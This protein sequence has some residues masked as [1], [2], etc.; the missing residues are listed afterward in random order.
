M[1]RAERH[2]EEERLVGR[3]GAFFD[4][5]DGFLG[6]ARQVVDLIQ[7]F[8]D[9]V[10]LDDGVHVARMMDAMK[11]VKATMDGT[12][13]NGGSDR[14]APFSRRLRKDRS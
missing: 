7:T 9:L 8:D 11:V 13:R 10:I 5:S 6:Q 12:V 4:V 14:R 3:L 1:R 2:I